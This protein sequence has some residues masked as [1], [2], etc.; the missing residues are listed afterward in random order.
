MEESSRDRS[1]KS[2]PTSKVWI[3]ETLRLLK[4]RADRR[5]NCAEQTQEEGEIRVAVGG[6]GGGAGGQV[7][8]KP[9]GK[10]GRLG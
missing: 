4:P 10:E 6:K 1:G 8:M 7:R 5:S 9:G 3:A 2:L